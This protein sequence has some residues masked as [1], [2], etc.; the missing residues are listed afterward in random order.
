MSE[1]IKNPNLIDAIR[2]INVNGKL[3]LGSESEITL[4]DLFACSSLIGIL[5]GSEFLPPVDTA[6]RAYTQATEMIKQRKKYL[7]ILNKGII[8]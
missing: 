1:K 7:D 5:E 8:K 3:T 2:H 6:K 4:F